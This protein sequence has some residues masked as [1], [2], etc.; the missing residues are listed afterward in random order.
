MPLYQGN[1]MIALNRRTF[2]WSTD[3]TA[4]SLSRFRSS[5]MSCSIGDVGRRGQKDRD[6]RLGSREKLP[7]VSVVHL[8]HEGMFA[9]AKP[10]TPCGLPP[11]RLPLT[12]A[13]NAAKLSCKPLIS[14][15]L[16]ESNP[17]F[18]LERAK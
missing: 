16:G 7:K 18:S 3:T 9:K 13:A 5:R 8:F 4:I 1:K 2:W 12:T 6:C 15:S 17:C 10:A 14:R 11:H